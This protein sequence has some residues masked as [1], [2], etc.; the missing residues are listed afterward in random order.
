L[1]AATQWGGKTERISTVIGKR[2]IFQSATWQHKN[3][4]TKMDY[5]V[6]RAKQCKRDRVAAAKRHIVKM[7]GVS[8]WIRIMFL[9]LAVSLL[10]PSTSEGTETCRDIALR[11]AGGVCP[12]SSAP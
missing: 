5:G 6:P 11:L 3:I 1:E 2:Q 7:E 4:A 12:W 9:A 8:M 10:A